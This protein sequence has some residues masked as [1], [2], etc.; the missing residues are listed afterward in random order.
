M[1]AKSNP[2]QCLAERRARPKT[3]AIIL[4]DP[5]KKDVVKPNAIFDQDDWEVIERLKQALF[6]LAGYQFVFL[7][8]HDT[9]IKDLMEIRDN[10]DYALNLCDEGYNNDPQK[11]L[12]IPALLEKLDIHYTGSSPRTLAYCFDK[13]L[14]K[15]LAREM[16]ISTPASYYYTQGEL[17]LP[18]D[19]RWPVLVKPN[20]GDGSHGIWQQSLANNKE[21]LSKAIIYLRKILGKATLLIEEFLPGKDLTI[22]LIGNPA[23]KIH[24]LPIIEEDYSRIPEHLPK[25]CGYE[26]KWLPDS[27]YWQI[28]SV[29]ADLTPE[30]EKIIIEGSVKLASRLNC[31]DYARIDWRLDEQG[32]PQILEVNPNCGWCW[33]GHLAKMAN[34]IGWDYAKLMQQILKSAEKR[35][36]L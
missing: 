6:D 12:H 9:L 24:V 7:S 27:P 1:D 13:S 33:D 31:Q 19:M 3:I 11:E 16:G 28:T 18:A 8:N 30:V 15:C 20:F 21:E 32:Q 36:G 17:R 29:P 25:I 4:G 22:G 10:I 14:V 26:A 2:Y 23:D 34:L 35:L 5:S